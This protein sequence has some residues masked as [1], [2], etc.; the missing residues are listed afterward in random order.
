MINNIELLDTLT[1]KIR[2]LQEQKKLVVEHLATHLP[3]NE[4]ITIGSFK[5]RLTTPTN[6]YCS[7]TALEKAYPMAY[8]NTVK[9]NT[10]NKITLKRLS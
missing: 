9:F 1:T 3:E 2:K 7:V 4:T 8:I 6:R 10:S 5:V